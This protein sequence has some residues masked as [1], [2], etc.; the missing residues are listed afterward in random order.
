MILIFNLEKYRDRIAFHDENN[1]NVTYEML[2]Q[3]SKNIEN[4]IGTRKLIYLSSKNTLGALSYYIAFLYTGNVVQI[5]SEELD[6]RILT[7]YLDKYF[8]SFLP[9]LGIL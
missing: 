9:S 4:K 5:V 3:L 7:T 8:R 2:I 6:E 1:N